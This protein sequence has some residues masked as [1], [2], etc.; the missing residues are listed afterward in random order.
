M[1]QMPFEGEEKL[2]LVQ[3]RLL[4]TSSPFLPSLPSLLFHYSRGKETPQSTEQ[5]SSRCA[6]TVDVFPRGGKEIWE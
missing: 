5:S 4:R 6:D 2:A 1:A 3:L